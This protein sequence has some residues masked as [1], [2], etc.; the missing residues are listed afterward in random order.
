MSIVFPYPKSICFTPSFKSNIHIILLPPGLLEPEAVR[1]WYNEEL[2]V[3]HPV[4]PWWRA[5]SDD[6]THIPGLPTPTQWHLQPPL[7]YSTLQGAQVGTAISSY[8]PSTDTH[9]IIPTS[10]QKELITLVI[11]S[12]AKTLL[13]LAAIL[14]IR[15]SAIMDHGCVIFKPVLLAFDFSRK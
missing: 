5:G 10:F 9:E 12:E 2:P 13:P 15:N 7:Q 1:G 3:R 4:F 8:S 14:P 6:G 11:L